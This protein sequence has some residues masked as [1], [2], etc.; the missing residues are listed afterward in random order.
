MGTLCLVNTTWPCWV[1]NPH[2]GFGCPD[3]TAGCWPYNV[4]PSESVVWNIGVCKQ[5]VRKW[6]TQDAHLS[7]YIT[8]PPRRTLQK[9]YMQKFTSTGI[10][11]PPHDVS[12]IWCSFGA[13]TFDPSR[14]LF[15]LA[16]YPFDPNVVY[17]YWYLCLPLHELNMI[18]WVWSTG[19][20]YLL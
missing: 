1:T 17:H 18:W 19:S 9:G 20:G 2:S 4:Y 7:I 11:W 13:M 10:I 5:R 15:Y 16:P 14:T 3:D 6:P 12:A 8:V